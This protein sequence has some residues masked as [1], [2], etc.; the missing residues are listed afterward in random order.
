MVI[1]SAGGTKFKLLLFAFTVLL[2][3]GSVYGSPKC[4]I[5]R[6]SSDADVR[7]LSQHSPTLLY[8]MPTRYADMKSASRGLACSGVA[9]VAFDGEGFKSAAWYDDVGLYLF[10]PALSQA[11]GLSVKTSADLFL[12]ITVAVAFVC[13]LCGFLLTAKTD[14]GRR[15][16]I[17]T[18]AVMSCLALVGGDVY[19]LSAAFIICCVP[20]IV[21]FM[22]HNRLTCSLLLAL[23]LVGLAAETANIIRS[24]TGTAL[25]IFSIVIIATAYQAKAAFRAIIAAVLCLG[26]LSGMLIYRHLY[27]QRDDFLRRQPGGVIQLAQG[28]VFWHSVYIGLAFIKNSEVPLYSD[29]IADQKVHQLQPQAAL[30]SPEYEHILKQQTLNLV[31]HMPMLILENIFAKLL[32]VSFICLAAMN[33]GV[34][35]LI[36]CRGCRGLNVAFWLAI[37]FTALPGII[38]MPN[39]RYIL[40]SIMFAVLYGAYSVECAAHDPLAKTQLRVVRR[41]MLLGSH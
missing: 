35:A 3:L 26:F 13:G 17:I 4:E 20:W 37:G 14:L 9:L 29:G 39:P 27:N 22:N 40:S 12:V 15:M 34:Y 25:M 8:F 24:H 1:H 31:R 28:H 21:V 16:G 41:F 11:T 32:I 36:L 7:G 2:H 19:A 23:F 18:F 30:Y 6:S 5:S 33:F 38:V 10:V